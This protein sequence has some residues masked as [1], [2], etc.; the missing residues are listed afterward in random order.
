M[1]AFRLHCTTEHMYGST[2]RPLITDASVNY[3]MDTSL[4][5]TPR[6]GVPVTR[7]SFFSLTFFKADSCLASRDLTWM[8]W[9]GFETGEESTPDNSNLVAKSKE[10]RVI[11]SSKQII[12]NK[13]TDGEGMRARVRVIQES[14]VGFK[15]RLQ[16]HQSVLLQVSAIFRHLA[17]S[18]RLWSNNDDIIILNNNFYGKL[19][20]FCL[21][22]QTPESER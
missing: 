7:S 1:I 9:T 11:G 14:N 21:W 22:Y 20:F 10:V 15:T 16:T 17:P 6:V 12:D 5:Q 18:S 13:Q 19:S 4:F 8:A 2:L 3:K